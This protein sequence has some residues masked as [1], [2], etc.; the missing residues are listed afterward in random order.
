MTI[1]GKKGSV[2]MPSMVK[3]MAQLSPEAEEVEVEEI[4]EESLE[5]LLV[6]R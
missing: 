6:L 5:N 1:L 2:I 4:N 3:M